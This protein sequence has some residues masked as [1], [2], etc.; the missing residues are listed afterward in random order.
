MVGGGGLAVG[1]VTV[2]GVRPATV[3]V[4]IDYALADGA[5]GLALRREGQSQVLGTVVVVGGRGRWSGTAL[6]PAGPAV[7][8]VLDGAGVTQ[9]SAAFD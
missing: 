8:A 5:Y 3:S 2:S 4:A 1:W 6:L 9:C 7:V